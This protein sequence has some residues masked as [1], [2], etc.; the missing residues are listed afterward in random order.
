MIDQ[1]GNAL[2]PTFISSPPTGNSVPIGPLATKFTIKNGKVVVPKP[3]KSGPQGQ[4]PEPPV[5]SAAPRSRPRPL[6]RNGEALTKRGKENEVRHPS[7]KVPDLVLFNRSRRGR[8][9]AH[10]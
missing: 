4:V 5:R 6:S 2:A 8:A 10:S 9:G 1:A 3:K 7:S